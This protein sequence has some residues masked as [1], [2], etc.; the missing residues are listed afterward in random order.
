MKTLKI[1][2]KPISY[3][4]TF[5]ILLQGCTVYKKQNI[6]LE[7]AV[8]TKN[9]VKL[10]TKEN[11]KQ[12]H[13]YVTTNN[14]EYYGTKKVNNEIIIIPLQEENIKNIRTV[15]KAAST[16]ATLLTFSVGTLVF[17]GGVALISFTSAF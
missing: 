13:L 1:F 3:L 12:K 4:L 8:A 5:L 9:R 16:I 2:I 11:E 14:G 17:L 7:Q 15:D 10:V 6:S